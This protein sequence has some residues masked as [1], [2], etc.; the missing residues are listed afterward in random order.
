MPSSV[1]TI[2][3]CLLVALAPAL[4]HGQ[5]KEAAP[6]RNLALIA[7]A[8]DGRIQQYVQ[9]LQPTM[10]RELDFVRQVCD[11]TPEQRPK[12]KAAADAAVKDAA[13]AMLKP[14]RQPMTIIATKAVRDGI[15]D[16]LKNTLTADQLDNFK[17]E[18]ASR[19]AAIKKAA[20]QSLVSQIDGALFLSQEQR[21][22]ISTALDSNWQPEWEHWLSMRQHQFGE[23]YLPQ[24]PDQ[25]IVPHLSAE[26]QVV[27]KGMQKIMF[28]AWQ[29]DGRRRDDVW[30]TGKAKSA[31]K[32]K[33]PKG[34]AAA[35]KAVTPEP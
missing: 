18:A 26:Q 30:W 8:D 15:Q 24:V 33:A 21:G 19:D 4:C 35:A 17:A 31:S 13:K 2:A 5:Q 25:H 10:W 7:Q 16:A 28:N 3:T 32:A 6:A 9:L 11:L 22:K 12:L 34:K 14:Q 1:K 23:Q 27:W 20:I 29:N